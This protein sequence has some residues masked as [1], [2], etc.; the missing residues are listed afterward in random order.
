MITVDGHGNARVEVVGADGWWVEVD[1]DVVSADFEIA[2]Q[3]ITAH[4][5]ELLR[6]PLTHIRL[7]DADF[8]PGA[9]G[10]YRHSWGDRYS[11]IDVAYSRYRS[12]ASYVNTLAHELTHLR[13]HADGRL[14]ASADRRVFENEAELAGKAAEDMFRSAYAAQRR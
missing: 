11:T 2:L 7:C 10:L 12:A 1:R 9:Y 13:Q 4:L 14:T 5:P 6:S 8:I 3:F